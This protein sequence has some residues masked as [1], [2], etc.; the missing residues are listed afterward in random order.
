MARRRALSARQAGNGTAESAGS[1]LG[2]THPLTRAI[3]AVLR[4]GRQWWTCAAILAGAL[5]AQLDR[6][7][8]AVTVAVS[9]GLVLLTLTV[10]ILAL[11]QRVRDEAIHLIADGREA[12]PIA[13]VQR[14][15]RRLLSRKTT[16]ALARTLETMLRQALRPT[17]IMTRGARPLF[18]A[19][20]ITSVAPDLLA[21]ISLLQTEQTRARG[22]AM[23]ERLL[24]YSDSPLYARE[25]RV[26]GEELH[27]IR[28]ALEE[29]VQ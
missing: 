19:R 3:D 7:P 11:R 23:T 29:Q 27:R 13:V 14:Q 25:P 16:E 4:L 24:A 28:N 17:R 5:I 6:H 1:V 15:R 18:S 9:A 12:L 2:P 26:L 10:V 20:V 22:V 21:V 8:W